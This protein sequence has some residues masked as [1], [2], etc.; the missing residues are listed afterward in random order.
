[1][2]G[3]FLWSFDVVVFGQRAEHREQSGRMVHDYI[4][5]RFKF[6]VNQIPIVCLN[7]VMCSIGIQLA[8]SPDA[9]ARLN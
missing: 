1:M 3:T 8:H 6:F 2:V 9:A 4:L 7:A 5:P